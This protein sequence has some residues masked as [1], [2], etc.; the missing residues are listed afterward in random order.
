MSQKTNNKDCTRYY[1]NLQEETVAKDMNATICSNSGANRFCK[2]DLIHNPTMLFECKTVTSPKTSFSIK[3]EWI[4][5]NEQE[6]FSQRVDNSCIVFNFEPNGENYYIIDKKLM[7]YL[8][9]KLD[10][11]Q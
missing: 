11:E 6:R 9:E 10:E 4:E 2:G 3:K 5:K 1:S 8:L 7:Q